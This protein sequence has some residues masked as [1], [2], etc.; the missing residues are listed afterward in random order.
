[1]VPNNCIV[2]NENAFT[3]ASCPENLRMDSE[4]GGMKSVPATSLPGTKIWKRAL[5]LSAVGIGLTWLPRLFSRRAG[6]LLLPDVLF[7]VGSVF[8]V[9]GLWGLIKNMG[10]FN[11]MKYGTKSLLR[12]FQGKR[13]Q[14]QDKMAGGFLEYVNSRSRDREAPWLVAI[15][16][17]LM[18]LSAVAS[19][20]F[21]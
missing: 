17:V 10:T 12:M 7:T 8:L 19:I 16:A 20:P 13:E 18:V 21:L 14:P 6:A 11:S 1:M 5:L 9:V 4:N 15:A 2:V 3:H